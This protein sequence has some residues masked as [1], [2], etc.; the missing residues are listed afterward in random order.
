[1]FYFE[2]ARLTS[3]DQA[4]KSTE[5]ESKSFLLLNQPFQTGVEVSIVQIHHQ[6]VG[7]QVGAVVGVRDLE[8]LGI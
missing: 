2:S 8:E 5:R 1:M 4:S 7:V 3:H 6:S